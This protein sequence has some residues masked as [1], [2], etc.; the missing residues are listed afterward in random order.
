MMMKACV[1]GRLARLLSVVG[2]LVTAACSSS[3]PPPQAPAET[4]APAAAA[5]AATSGPGRVYGQ[6]PVL[7]NVPSIVVLEPTSERTYPEVT[8]PVMDQALQTFLPEVLFVRVGQKTEFRN[9]DEVLHNVN[10]RDDETKNQA[11]NVAIP[12][13]AKYD[14]TFTREGAYGVRCDIHP[15]MSALIVV[16]KSPYAVQ[17]D[18]TGAYE[19]P[20]V[21]PGSYRLIAYAGSRKFEKPL[22]VAGAT[23]ATIAGS[24]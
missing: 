20:A 9:S 10:V 23:E 22:E 15:A 12:T 14:Y 1:A 24:D 17:T 7:N 3:E 4:P 11:F 21:E 19:I 5:P 13:D 2:V 6:V 18:A 16:T 8:P